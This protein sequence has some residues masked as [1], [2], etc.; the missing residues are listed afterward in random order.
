MKCNTPG[1]ESP[2]LWLNL[3]V[4]QPKCPSFVF[5]SRHSWSGKSHSVAKFR[6]VATKVSFL[7][8]YP[9]WKWS[10]V[11]IWVTFY[12]TPCIN[13]RAKDW[14][15]SQRALVCLIWI[16]QSYYVSPKCRVNFT[17]TSMVNNF[18][19]ICNPRNI[20]GEPVFPHCKSVK[21]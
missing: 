12:L 8:F 13:Y 4:L 17:M 1:V 15:N 21:F 20:V 16:T 14:G 3:D 2:I 18:H 19:Y 7:C 9:T 10:D 5:I 6:C 11:F